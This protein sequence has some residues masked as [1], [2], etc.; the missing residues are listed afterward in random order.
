MAEQSSSGNGAANQGSGPA[1]LGGTTTNNSTQA[2]GLN[3]KNNG[4]AAPER[5]EPII[6]RK[7]KLK[8]DFTGEEHEVDDDQLK[9]D[10]RLRKYS[11][12]VMNDAKKLR[13]QSETFIQMLKT[14][15]EKVLGDPRIGVDL[16]KFCEDY[17]SGHLEQEM[18]D[19]KD[20]EI[21]DLKRQIQNAEDM[22]KNEEKTAQD[23]KI[24]ALSK[25]WRDTYL[26]DASES[27]VA[28]GL[29][30]NPFTMKRVF[31]YM[32]LFNERG[33][34]VQ[35]KNVMDFV[36]Q[37]YKEELQAIFGS[38]E[39]DDLDAFVG[40][41]IGK[42]IRTHDI[43]KLKGQAQQF[44]KKPEGAGQQR[45]QKEKKMTQ[46]EWRQKRDRMKQG[47]E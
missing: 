24:E 21:M 36:R 28:A 13:S 14:S 43:S 31:Y 11:D 7:H 19:P 5:K 6:L 12:Q 1:S 38:L 34:P 22:K 20:R 4:S 10:W 16:R 9:R 41:E 37:D 15:P 39:G 3:N 23:K 2:G 29:P 45:T 40:Q 30:K 18:M 32:N 35:A 27:L 17:L 46:Y 42:K 47:L 33:K 25:E 44:G 8:D 26:K